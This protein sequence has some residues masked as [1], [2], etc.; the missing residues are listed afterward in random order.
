MRLTD[1]ETGDTKAMP[2]GTVTGL[3]EWA[4]HWPIYPE[5]PSR[6]TFEA[7]QMAD[8]AH[9]VG[10]GQPGYR[11]VHKTIRTVPYPVLDVDMGNLR[12][13]FGNGQVV[14][15]EPR[16]SNALADR[17]VGEW[18]VPQWGSLDLEAG[19]Y[20][21]RIDRTVQMDAHQDTT[22][23]CNFVELLYSFDT[24]EDRS[25]AQALA[26][27]RARTAPLTA[28]LDLA[29][30]ERLLGPVLTEEVGE[31]FP[32][33]HWNRR[34]GGR[35]VAMEGQAELRQLHAHGIMQLV[36]VLVSRQ[37]ERKESERQRLRVASRWYW[38][39]DTEAEPVLKF[40][41]YWTAIES[42][43]LGQNTNI[44]P[45]KAAVARLLDVDRNLIAA[46][47]GRVYGVRNRL[48]HGIE[49]AA[50]DHDLTT[51]RCIAESLLEE[52]LLGTVSPDRLERLRAS[53][54]D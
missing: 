23:P 48:L 35:T 32:D 17:R 40:I 44:T 7:W 49:R 45:V 1:I 3:D 11:I 12:L 37:V 53:L 26:E 5:L 4:E 42:L 36:D 52:Q 54:A 20:T 28:G 19:T 50:S 30:G 27:G 8:E 16:F 6:V 33:G 38:H 43:E 34:L 18:L 47:V 2:E 13:R 25:F 39:A 22:P 29:F 10:G 24:H 9:P 46:Q 31:L 41:A 21:P 51:V 15:G 14:R